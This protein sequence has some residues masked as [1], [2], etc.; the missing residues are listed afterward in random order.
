MPRRSFPTN[1]LCNS[2]NSKAQLQFTEPN[3]DV[4]NV[5]KLSVNIAGMVSAMNQKITSEE[6]KLGLCTGPILCVCELVSNTLEFNFKCFM[7]LLLLNYNIL[8]AK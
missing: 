3:V 7:S 2:E 4:S 5:T 6:P 8:A 1:L